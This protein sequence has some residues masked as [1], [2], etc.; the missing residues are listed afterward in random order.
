MPDSSVSPRDFAGIETLRGLYRILEK[1]PHRRRLAFVLRNVQGLEVA[2]V[3]QALDVSESTA[4]RE[5]S[6]AKEVIRVRSRG[7]P[8]LWQYLQSLEGGS[9]A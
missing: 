9:H 6:R 8:A 4:K 3:A 5:I 2:D 1:M 7:E